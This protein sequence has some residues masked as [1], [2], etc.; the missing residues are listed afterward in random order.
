MKVS[1]DGD[2]SK[3]KESL[4]KMANINFLDLHKEIGEY[5][6]SSTQQRFRAGKSPSGE[7]WPKSIRAKI[8]RGQ[9]LRDTKRLQNSITS[10]AGYD[11]VEIG[12]NVKYAAVHQF[13][14]TIKPKRKNYLKFKIGKRWAQKKKV[15]IPKREF[16]GINNNDKDEILKIINRHIEE[17]S[18]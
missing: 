8:D 11:K 10:K 17:A 6:V 16:L 18:R 13:G 14:A 7:K 9:T 4:N 3:L 12:T 15:D 2:F 5:V 1:L